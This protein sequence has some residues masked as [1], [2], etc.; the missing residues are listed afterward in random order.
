V[1][2]QHKIRSQPIWRGAVFLERLVKGRWRELPVAPE[3]EVRDFTSEESA[4]AT[5]L[6]CGR[7][8]VDALHALPKAAVVPSSSLL[9]LPFAADE[10]LPS[11]LR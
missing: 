9:A 3:L 8:Y 2:R 11:C 5:A 10:P 7:S 1:A 4:L 6:N